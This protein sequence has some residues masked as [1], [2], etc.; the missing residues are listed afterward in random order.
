MLMMATRRREPEAPSD[1]LTD[2]DVAARLGIHR[3]TVWT[4]LDDGL[5]P[6]PKRVGVIRPSNGQRRSRTT[7]WLRA[8]IDL[9]VLCGDMAAFRRAKARRDRDSK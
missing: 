4:W 5:L 2:V 8:D 6:E 3:A 1:W 9:F 7:R